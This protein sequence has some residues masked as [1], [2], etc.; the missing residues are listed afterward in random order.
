MQDRKKNFWRLGASAVL[1]CS[2]ATVGF[3]S[4]LASPI[5]YWNQI[6]DKT[7][8]LHSIVK[9]WQAKGQLKGTVVRGFGVDGK[10][11]NKYCVAC[12]GALKNKKIVG[13]TI[14]W[15]MK[16]NPSSHR[17][18]GGR[19]LDP[20]SGSIYKANM[21]LINGGK[22]LKVRGYIGISLFGRSQ[23]WNRIPPNQVKK[24]LS[25]SWQPKS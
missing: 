6:S 18:E 13:M 7:G 25:P 2:M 16:Y 21:T 1:L 12:E 24:E 15:G 3:A 22:Q 5:G 14:I 11:P 20:D 8:K 19:I 4:Q 17:W 23:V 10:A 9:I